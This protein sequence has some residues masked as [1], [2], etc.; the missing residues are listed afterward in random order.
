[1]QKPVAARVQSTGTCRLCL[2][3]HPLVQSHIIPAFQFK[4]LKKGDGRYYEL[5]TNP[6][7]KERS[8][9]RG[10]TERLLCAECDNVR[11]QRNEAYYAK[12]WTRGPLAAPQEFGRFLIFR[13]HDYKRTKNCLLSVL[14]RMSISSHEVF[15]EV[16]LGTKHEETLRAGL[17][18]DREFAEDEYAVTVTAPFF[19]GKHH[20][21]FILQPDSHRLHGNRLYRCVIAGILYTSVVGSARL[22]P[23]LH[24]LSL[25]KNEFPVARMEVQDIPFLARAVGKIGRAQAL[26]DAAPD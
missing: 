12:L 14:W 26:R 15:R 3:E 9:Q 1:M 17:L 2:Q 10:F 25:R 19:E 8:G 23:E 22:V 21:D 24:A 20:E 5:S 18:A 13:D 7:E 6:T 16:S 11:I 4:P